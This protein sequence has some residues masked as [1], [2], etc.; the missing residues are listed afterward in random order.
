[1]T[2]NE[3]QAEAMRT[4]SREAPVPREIDLMIWALGLTGE[5]GEFADLVKKQVGHG[6]PED[7]EKVRKELGDVLWYLSVLADAFGWALEDVAWA[8]VE[9]LRKRYP[10]GFTSAD[11][12]ARRDT[13]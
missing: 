8:N 2:L 13:P 10:N 4:A 7:R 12:Q 11:S 9:K 1:M 5:A 3:Y 6:H